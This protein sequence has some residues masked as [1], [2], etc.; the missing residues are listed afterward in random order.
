MNTL[1]FKSEMQFSS[2][3]CAASP[4]SP[5]LPYL[6]GL[7]QNGSRVFQLHHITP[8]E[9]R[10]KFALV[11]SDRQTE[12]EEEEEEELEEMEEEEEEGLLSIVSDVENITLKW[13]LSLESPFLLGRRE[14]Q[15][16]P[17]TAGS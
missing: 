17:P 14:P 2:L 6:P 13:H 7:T 5:A 9:R 8:G 16:P 3:L 11:R 12:A 4:V 1:T 15:K 10:Q